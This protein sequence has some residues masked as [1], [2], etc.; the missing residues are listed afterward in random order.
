M[1]KRT[2]QEANAIADRILADPKVKKVWS[3]WQAKYS[4]FMDYDL[5]ESLIGESFRKAILAHDFSRQQ[6]QSSF[7]KYLRWTFSKE[8]KKS[9]DRNAICTFTTLNSN[10]VELPKHELSE[11]N[12]ES[13]AAI[14]GWM[15]RYL[16]EE[17]R[18]AIEKVYLQGQTPSQVAEQ[19]RCSENSVMARVEYGLK[20]MRE[21]A[22]QKTCNIIKTENVECVI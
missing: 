20:K 1:P 19:E 16:T 21:I 5:V 17:V 4:K 11:R 2:T 10:T 8:L 18:S 3:Y 6:F 15:D 13:V 14:Y 7:V 12:Q 22:A 9:Y